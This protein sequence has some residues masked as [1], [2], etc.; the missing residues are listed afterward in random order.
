M[1]NF[2]RIAIAF[3]SRIECVMVIISSSNGLARLNLPQRD[4]DA[5]RYLIPQA[6]ID[7]LALQDRGGERR[8]IDR[9]LQPRPQICDG[10]EMVFMGVG[11]NDA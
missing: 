8:R 10:T 6:R 4:L 7:Q 3:G 9:R 5:D 11:Q 2:V 1:P